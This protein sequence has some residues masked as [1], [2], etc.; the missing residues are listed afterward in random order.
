M[1]KWC[2]ILF[3]FLSI[4]AW[5]GEELLEI[6][7]YVHGVWKCIGYSKDKGKT[8]VEGNNQAYC[9]V[10]SNSVLMASGDTIT[11]KSVLLSEEDSVQYVTI[12]F[13]E[14]DSAWII[15][16]IRPKVIM[17]QIVN[18]TEEKETARLIFSVQ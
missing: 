16:V 18:I 11:V 9:R 2:I 7:P 12:I 15:S 8:V 4:T 6:S 13:N 1:K 5:A 17:V 10:S 3:T 14:L